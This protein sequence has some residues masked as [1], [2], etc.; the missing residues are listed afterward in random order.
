MLED[1]HSR[2]MK[3]SHCRS[4]GSNVSKTWLIIIL[5]ACNGHPCQSPNPGI[6]KEKHAGS[7][8]VLTPDDGGAAVKDSRRFQTWPVKDFVAAGPAVFRDRANSGSLDP[9]NFL[10]GSNACSIQGDFVGAIQFLEWGIK[11]LGPDVDAQFYFQLGQLHARMGNWS[12]AR[13]SFCEGL[14]R[15]A[16]KP[17]YMEML[18]LLEEEE[19]LTALL[20]GDLAI[21]ERFY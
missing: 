6:T 19:V 14:K 13:Q 1:I 21:A 5:L 20:L 15:D 17:N 16:A 3:V 11:A 7:Q 2:Y 4:N 10:V 9:S 8:D 12:A 18:A